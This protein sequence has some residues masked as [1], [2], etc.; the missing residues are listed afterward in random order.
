MEPLAPHE[1]VFVDSDFLEDENHGEIACVD[2]HGGNPDDPDWKTAH[3]GVV[4]DPTYPDAEKTC[5]ECHGEITEN[6]PTSLHV[7]LRPYK[8]TIDKRATPNSVVHNKLGCAMEKNCSACH[9][10]CGQC[11]ISRPESVEGGF[12]EGHLFQK[13]P[14]MEQ[15]CTA[16]HGS[17]VQKEYFGDNE[18]AQPD[19]HKTKYM[20]CDKCH[21]G[22]EMH[23]DGKQYEHRYAV[24]NGA[25]CTDCHD[26]IYDRNAENVVTHRIHKDKATCQVCHSQTYKN[27]SSCHVADD[28]HGN[29]FFKTKNSWLDFK[30]GLNPLKSDKRP[31]KFAVL[32]HAP[33]DKKTFGFYVK[34]GLG[35]FDKLPTWKFATPHNIL[36]KTKQNS[37]C[38]SC[39]GNKDLFLLEKDVE[40]SVKGANKGVIVPDNMIPKK[41]KWQPK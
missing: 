4:K 30:I 38:N 35:N 1:K 13:K 28:E 39:H 32:R 8:L 24:E 31:E 17:R 29:S 9:S 34:D 21:S 6:Y 36:R 26:K 2:C 7:S 37:S 41:Q 19:V 16:C 10:S 27:C 18:G 3:N 14:P 12:L 40:E 5:G 20:K 22:E 25:K 15:V 33:V 11:H 23:G